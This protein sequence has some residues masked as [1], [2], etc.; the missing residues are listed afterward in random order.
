MQDTA[1]QEKFIQK[2]I[3]DK[4]EEVYI[5]YLLNFNFL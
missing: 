3:E 1:K 2:N 4:I 5:V